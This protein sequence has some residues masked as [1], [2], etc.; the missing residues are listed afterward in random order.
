MQGVTE[1]ECAGMTFASLT[2]SWKEIMG[3]IM[4]SVAQG[5]RRVWWWR[6]RGF[7]KKR[8]QRWQM[9]FIRERH[10][11]KHS[12]FYC[13]L[14]CER[15]QLALLTDQVKS[16]AENKNILLLKLG[17]PTKDKLN[18]SSLVPWQ[19]SVCGEICCIESALLYNYLEC[20]VLNH[21]LRGDAF[22]HWSNDTE[23][24]AK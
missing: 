6:W 17:K 16:T 3:F 18:S 4:L 10:A 5:R 22:C 19:L 21:E 12:C 13:P 20:E 8:I 14:L 1:G 7:K 2:A 11:A 9:C 15:A 23:C 24:V